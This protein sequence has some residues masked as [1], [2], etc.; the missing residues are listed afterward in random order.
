MQMNSLKWR[1]IMVKKT[2]KEGINLVYL[3]G[4]KFK[5]VYIRMNIYRPMGKEAAKNALL[6]R[7]LKA[8]CKLY[9]KQQLEKQLESL[10]GAWLGADVTKSGDVQVISFSISLPSDRYTGSDTTLRAAKLLYEVVLNPDAENGAFKKE[11]VNIEKNNLKSLIES[12]FNDKKEYAQQ[13]CI[14]TMFQNSAFAI[15]ELGT[16][17]E[18][19]K[20][21]ENNL[22]EHYD[23]ILKNSRI[24]IFV[25]GNCD[26][27]AVARVFDGVKSSAVIP[28]NTADNPQTELK[29]VM[30]PQDVN[31]GKLMMGFKTDIDT[32]SRDYY[33]LLVFNSVYGSGTHSKLFCN[34]REKLS[35]AYY[36]YARL[37]RYKSVIFVGSGIEFANYEKAKEEI[38]CQ[39]DKIRKGNVT[40]FELSSAKKSLINAYKSMEDEP[41]RIISAKTG[42]AIL[43]EEIS[44][45]EIV[46][47][48]DSVTKEDVIEMASHVWLDTIYFLKGNENE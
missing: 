2:L 1:E 41:A 9:N 25:S 38:I 39:L 47:S 22:K 36:A 11:T 24:D 30:E 37:N 33:K 28:E 34:V 45:P 8:G 6:A 48:I 12:V 40:E 21:N 27:D 23:N 20:I 26:I 5:T 29:T 17:D 18:L 32:K 42:N 7:V 13:R 31:Q 44:L 4:D 43:G 3:P 19:S 16:A 35:L 14:E 10:Y 15:H 46:D